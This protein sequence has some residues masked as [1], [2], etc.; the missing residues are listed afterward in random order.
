MPFHC[1][2]FVWFFSPFAYLSVQLCIFV[3]VVFL[4]NSRALQQKNVISSNYMW[5]CNRLE[6][7]HTPFCLSFISLF[8]LITMTPKE[9]C[10]LYWTK[11]CNWSTALLFSS[12]FTVWIKQNEKKPIEIK[13]MAF[14]ACVHFTR[15]YIHKW[16]KH[17]HTNDRNASSNAVHWISFASTGC[18]ILSQSFSNW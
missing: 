14:A 6:M 5:K 10:P 3:V 15:P 4:I 12:Q 9:N 2:W 11:L 7:I 16:H 8:Q 13:L 17:I 1:K 18:E